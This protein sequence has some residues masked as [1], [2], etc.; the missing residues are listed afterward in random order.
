MYFYH[1]LPLPLFQPEGLGAFRL[2]TP[3]YQ[4]GKRY[5]HKLRW[6]LAGVGIPGLHREEVARLIGE[7]FRD[8]EPYKYSRIRFRGMADLVIHIEAGA[9]GHILIGPGHIAA[10][11]TP[12]QIPKLHELIL[13]ALKEE[14]PA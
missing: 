3:I 11:V 9:Y 1:Q 4:D 14:A 6:F 10:L 8:T 2:K 13:V 12:S 5:T 7:A